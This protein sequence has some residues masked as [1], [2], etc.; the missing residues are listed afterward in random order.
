MT[1]AIPFPR[2]ARAIQSQAGFTLLE[3]ITAMTAG[4]IILGVFVAITLNLNYMMISTGNY[5]DLD[6]YSRHTL[7]LLSRDI[8]NAS[9]V[10]PTSTNTILVLN[11][12]YSSPTTIT[13]SWDGSNN[14]TRTDSIQTTVILKNCNYLDFEYFTRVP[15]NNL[16]F[17]SVS[18]SLSANEAKLVSVSWRC[19]RSTLGKKL[20]TESVQTAQ[21]VLRN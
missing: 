20:N 16:Q 1:L 21:I 18:N 8:R 7:D 3:L 19:S 12:T 5:G 4:L 10:D 2:R 6:E 9:S 11:N 15:T 17:T 13:Y 14:V